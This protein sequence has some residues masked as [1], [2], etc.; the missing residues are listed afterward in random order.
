MPSVLIRAQLIPHLL[1]AALAIFIQDVRSASKQSLL[2]VKPVA[3]IL[4]DVALHLAQ[5]GQ[6]RR[7]V[8]RRCPV[9]LGPVEEESL[10]GKM[11]VG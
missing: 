9:A 1:F 5:I 3:V 8:G 11:A 6:A 4:E 7:I 2:L 10:D